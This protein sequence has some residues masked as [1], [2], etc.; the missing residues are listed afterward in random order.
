[1]M[2]LTWALISSWLPAPGSTRATVP[3][4][5]SLNSSVPRTGVS[6]AALM[7]V[8]A[9]LSDVPGAM[10]GTIGRPFESTTETV[11]FGCSVVPT[12]GFALIT[13]LRGTVLS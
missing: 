10:L 12:G 1:M 7:A 8:S 9:A 13:V 3:C 11:A 5:A 2:R 6:C 4:G